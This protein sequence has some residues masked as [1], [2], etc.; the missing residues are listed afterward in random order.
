MRRIKYIYNL[1]KKEKVF[2]YE[3]KLYKRKKYLF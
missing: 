2:F 1:K 3:L